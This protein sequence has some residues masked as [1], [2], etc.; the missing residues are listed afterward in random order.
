M[1]ANLAVAWPGTLTP[2]S[3]NQLGQ[4]LAGV[5]NDWHPPLMAEIWALIGG[6]L[7]AMLALQIGMHWLGIW[8]LA[9]T[10]RR[11]RAGK[12]AF[13]M[14][15]VGLT[16]IAIKYT[17]V[18]QKDTLLAS[19]F[20]AAFGMAAL[21]GRHRVAAILGV[22]GT[23]CRAN[24]VFALPP[25]FLSRAK[26]IK[27]LPALGLCLLA[28]AA[29]VP[30]SNLV[31]HR[32]LRAEETGVERSLQLFD[33]AGIARFSGDASVLPRG[34]EHAEHCYTPLFWDTLPIAGCAGP[35]ERLP[36][37]LTASWVRAIAAHP[38]AYAHHRLA[39]FN[40]AIFF[41]VPPMEQ[42][43]DAPAFH[44][45]DFTTRGMIVDFVTKNAFLWPATW[46]VIGVMLLFGELHPIARAL[47]LSGLTYGLAYAVVGVAADFRYFYWT[48]LAIQAAIMFQL[49]QVG[50]LSRWKPLAAATAAVWIAGYAARFM[51]MI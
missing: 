40:K 24:G 32:L 47:S 33:L 50:R 18:I 20:I 34:A 2:D 14:L 1:A 36:K 11:D 9:E 12:W 35:V 25:L 7:P 44:S 29:F 6:T 23:L 17:G 21:S 49:A 10:L 8:A 41:V 27:L 30:V 15:G 51:A 5:F 28:A 45:C 22:A 37:S 4:A 19:F 13:A 46:L 16:P 31:N 48:E 43:V 38:I 42:C 3:R 26:R 39:H